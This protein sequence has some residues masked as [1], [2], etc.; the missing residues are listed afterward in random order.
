ME[1]RQQHA[2]RITGHARCS[3]CT[4]P[5]TAGPVRA[6]ARKCGSLRTHCA[7]TRTRTAHTAPPR[8]CR[9]R[10]V[11][12]EAAQCPQPGALP[13]RAAALTAESADFHVQLAAC[14]SE[15]WPAGMPRT[16]QRR[17][18]RW[19]GF[20]TGGWAA[21]AAAAFSRHRPQ[22]AAAVLRRKRCS[23]WLRTWLVAWPTPACPAAPQITAARRPRTASS[24]RARPRSSS[25][26]ALA[27][28]GTTGVATC[29][30]WRTRASTST[31]QR[32]QG[33]EACWEHS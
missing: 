15:P 33:A 21:R 7:H 23:T 9:R 20:L 12:H 31:R 14:A 25:C 30:P 19:Q 27:H 16:V 32:S 13:A 3:A 11:Y 5:A 28:S 10:R 2:E 17:H 4:S 18:W 24:G 26:T 29:R 6:P 8:A 22:P 1:A